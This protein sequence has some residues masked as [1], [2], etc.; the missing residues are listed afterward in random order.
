VGQ[1][2][3]QL[4]DRD[5]ALT[6]DVSVRAGKLRP[7]SRS[8]GCG[9]LAQFLRPRMPEMI[10]YR[11]ALLVAFAL[12]LAIAPLH[13]HAEK[14]VALVIGNSAYAHVPQLANPKNDAADMAD[15]LEAMGFEVVRGLDL[16]LA[17]LRSTVRDFIGKLD[18]ADMALFYYAGH[19]LQVNGEN[20]IAPTDARLSSYLDLD[21]EAM[22]INLVMSAME[23]STKVNLVF[24]DAC[25]DNPLAE[26][27]AR[28][29][30]TRSGAVGRGLAKLGSG[31]GSLIAFATQPGNVALDGS[32]R[33][34]PFT[35]ALLKHLGT[36]GQGVT[37]DLILVRREVL[38]ATGGK[39]VPWDNSSLTGDVV[40]VPKAEEPKP[41]LVPAPVTE[42]PKADNTA[43]ITYWDSIKD[44][45]TVAYFEAYLTQYPQGTFA[46]LARLR[47]DELNK[48][49]AEPQKPSVAQAELLFWDQIKDANSVAMLSAYLEQYPQGAF[50]ALARAKVQLLQ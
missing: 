50:A 18:G 7:F 47:I 6:I 32:G 25:R 41:E 13:A 31:V 37:Q 33:N 36:P 19:G 40:L 48:Q 23:R 11:H 30:G 43:E 9:K 17:G 34:S 46:A 39:Q 5:G 15:K 20:Y 28:S 21:F 10:L 29:M 45:G 44:A 1:P 26:N 22:P 49:Q 16:D 12:A 8:P 14:R 24:L 38:D 2:G 42:T 4:A 35:T 3:K 27:L